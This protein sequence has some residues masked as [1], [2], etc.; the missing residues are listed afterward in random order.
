MSVSLVKSDFKAILSLVPLQTTD[1]SPWVNCF[2]L[3]LTCFSLQY[4]FSFM[5]IRSEP[6]MTDSR[7]SIK[8]ILWRKLIRL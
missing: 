4:R 7:N 1:R 8:L 6:A 2:S 3:H 5:F